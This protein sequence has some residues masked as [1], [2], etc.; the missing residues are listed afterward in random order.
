[1]TLRK[2]PVTRV[3]QSNTVR[4]TAS[5]HQDGGRVR[6]DRVNVVTALGSYVV[7]IHK[8]VLFAQLNTNSADKNMCH[9]VSSYRVNFFEVHRAWQ[10]KRQILQWKRQ[11]T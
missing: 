5:K 2:K 7:K 1:M 6:G 4:N 11:W 9:I 10:I 8:I 3:P